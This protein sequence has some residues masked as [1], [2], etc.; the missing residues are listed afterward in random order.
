MKIITN[1]QL[2]Y[3]MTPPNRNATGVLAQV[4][5]DEAG[6][7][8]PRETVRENLPRFYFPLP[9]S[10]ALVA[11]RG[12]QARLQNQTWGGFAERISLQP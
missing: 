11:Q 5:A 1:A 2:T 7:F 9:D 3:T 10:P 12:Y 6:G 8:Q 4:R